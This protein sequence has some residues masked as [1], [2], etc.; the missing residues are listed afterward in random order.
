MTIDQK[1]WW[2][3]D[4]LPYRTNQGKE[5]PC[6]EIVD[7]EGRRVA[8]TDEDTPAELQ[9]ADARLIAAA[10]DMKHALDH[11]ETGIQPDD[12]GNRIVTPEDMRII[13]AAIARAKGGRI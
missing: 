12:E 1:T 13:R 5:I 2:T 8:L 6:F 3:Y 10:P 7:R 4:Y 9:E 11:I